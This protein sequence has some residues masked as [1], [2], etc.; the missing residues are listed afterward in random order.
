MLFNFVLLAILILSIKIISFYLGEL[1]IEKKYIRKKIFELFM[2]F[3]KYFSKNSSLKIIQSK[4]DKR[5]L[6]VSCLSFV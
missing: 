6:D 3:S 2:A 4:D 5:T 1:V